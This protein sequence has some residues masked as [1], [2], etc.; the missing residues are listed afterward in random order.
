MVGQPDLKLRP[1]A[2]EANT[3]PPELDRETAVAALM[4]DSPQLRRRI[5]SKAQAPLDHLKSVK[6]MKKPAP[7]RAHGH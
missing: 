6:S 3:S 1:L 4:R 5:P 2:D 7:Y